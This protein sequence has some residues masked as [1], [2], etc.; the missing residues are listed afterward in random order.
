MSKG[1]YQ[2]KSIIQI[3]STPSLTLTMASSPI[4]QQESSR[5]RSRSPDTGAV[6]TSTD[7]NKRRTLATLK[8]ED[9]PASVVTEGKTETKAP[10]KKATKSPSKVEQQKQEDERVA[11]L[12]PKD[13]LNELSNYEFKHWVGFSLSR[14]GQ[15]H[16]L[17]LKQALEEDGESALSHVHGA[18]A[19][20]VLLSSLDT[21]LA[22]CL[23]PELDAELAKRKEWTKDRLACLRTMAVESK[24]QKKK[25]PKS[26]AA[27]T[28]KAAKPKAPV[29]K[30]INTLLKGVVHCIRKDLWPVRAKANKDGSSTP[31]D[32][33]DTDPESKTIKMVRDR[34]QMLQ[35]SEKALTL[36]QQ[37][38]LKVYHVKL[39]QL[40]A[41]QAKRAATAPA[42]PTKTKT[43]HESS[44]D[45]EE[46]DDGT[47]L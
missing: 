13:A 27:T 26:P 8:S 42:A 24:K 44:E 34:I 41:E 22:A 20:A 5:K 45:D 23:T 38:H 11:S 28:K 3:T 47:G 15:F 16:S 4:K 10:A 14:R 36:T 29:K 32:K 30:D 21:A 43:Q 25:T 17:I 2:G 9:V 40:L 37:Q 1:P 12:S 46:E 19:K 7:G 33:V 31:S 39:E 18:T 35:S 6:G